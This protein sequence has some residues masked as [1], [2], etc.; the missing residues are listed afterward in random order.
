MLFLLK[1]M[2]FVQINEINVS[3][4]IIIYFHSLNKSIKLQISKL[5]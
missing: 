1:F 3:N 2:E 5:Y 4:T